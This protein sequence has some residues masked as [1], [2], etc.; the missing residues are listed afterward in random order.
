MRIVVAGLLCVLATAAPAQDS[1]FSELR[2]RGSVLRNPAS[3]RIA[4]DWRGKTGLQFAIASNVGGGEI[5]LSAGHLGYTPTSGKPPFTGTFFSL[6]WTRQ[7]LGSRRLAI[8]A[9]PRLTDLRMD[10]D[11]PALVGGLRTE[12]EVIVGATARARYRVAGRTFLVADASLGALM[13]STKTPMLL[14]S[15][16]VGQSAATPRWL[17]EFLR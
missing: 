7:L 4:D 1:A 16:G 17:R 5:G 9:G 10:F 6:E 11:D 15:I 14:V 3:G 2:F 12:E 8:E 13:L